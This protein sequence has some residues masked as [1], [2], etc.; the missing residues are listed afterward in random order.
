MPSKDASAEKLLNEN[1]KLRQELEEL[2]ELIRAVRSDE[3]DALVI[4]TEKGDQVFSLKTADQ[5]Y[6]NLIEEMREGAVMLSE[7]NTVLYCNTSFGDMTKNP[8]NRIIGAAINNLI[9]PAHKRSFLNLLEQGRN[10]KGNKVAQITLQAT[11]GT[12]VPTQMSAKAL[13]M[14]G[15]TKATYVIATDLT[16]HMRE[17]VRSYT[18][19]LEEE[20]T[21]RKKAEKDLRVTQRK[22]EKKA[23]E[24]EEYANRM[25]QLAE[26]RLRKLRDTERMATIGQ[27]AGMVGHDIRNPLQT[28]A[29]ELYLQ[30][31]ELAQLPTSIPKNNLLESIN[32]VEEQLVYVNKIIA[33]LQDYSKPVKPEAASLNAADII[34]EA[35]SSLQIPPEVTVKVKAQPKALVIK[36]DPVIMKRIINNLVLNSIQAMP[37]GG[38]ITIETAQDKNNAVIAVKDTGNGIPNEYKD[39]IFTPLFTTKAKGQ[40]FGLAVVKRFVEAQKGEITFESENGK[41]TT[42]TIKLP[43]PQNCRSQS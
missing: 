36:A 17:E 30:R 14:D 2:R 23:A 5:T 28:V 21:R 4:Q 20:I 38:T 29:G 32:I 8:I 22:L 11:D 43:L 37:D 6:R 12:L 42:F 40:G 15:S 41:G 33:D 31:G 9:S 26:E 34:K 39:K 18:K 3:V 19:G 24:V 16:Q 7:D 10:G 27:T 35:L 13:D 1:K 25:E